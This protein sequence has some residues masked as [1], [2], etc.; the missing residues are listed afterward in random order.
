MSILWNAYQN[1][2]SVY[3]MNYNLSNDINKV[4]NTLLPLFS[5]G[6]TQRISKNSIVVLYVIL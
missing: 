6:K 4:T 5:N 2:D 1:K 3:M